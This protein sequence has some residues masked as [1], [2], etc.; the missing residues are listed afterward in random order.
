VAGGF[1]H[2]SLNDDFYWQP[3]LIFAQKGITFN[4]V[5]VDNLQFKLSYR[6]DYLSLPLLLGLNVGK[7]FSIQ[8]GPE[9]SHLLGIRSDFNG[10]T[11]YGK[12]PYFP[13]WDI[14]VIAGGQLQL[15]KVSMHA[16]IV[17]G[18]AEMPDFS[19]T[20]INGLTLFHVENGRH[21]SVQL[22]A[23]FHIHRSE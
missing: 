6:Y 10:Q 18:F 7:T 17:K 23:A 3:E 12:S 19:F 1:G 16:R 9:V 5:G 4:E 15:N 22:G 14:G 2:Y 13:D 20:D 21:L 8:L 11:Y